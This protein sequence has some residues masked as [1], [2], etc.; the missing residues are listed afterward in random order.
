[1]SA[2]PRRAD[3]F[4]W[5]DVCL[6]GAAPLHEGGDIPLVNLYTCGSTGVLNNCR[7]RRSHRVEGATPEVIIHGPW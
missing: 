4:M 2:L 7:D 5:R 3:F 1:M 6:F